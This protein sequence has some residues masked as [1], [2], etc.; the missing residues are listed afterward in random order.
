MEDSG[1]EEDQL[2]NQTTEDTSAAKRLKTSDGT[3]IPYESASTTPCGC[4]AA[5]AENSLSAMERILGYNFRNKDLLQEALTH[6]SWPYSRSYERLEF[7]GD[8]IICVTFSM[9]VYHTYPDLEPGQL[10]RIRAANISTEKLA[11]LAVRH[12]FHQYIRINAPAVEA[13]VFNVSLYVEFN[14]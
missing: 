12:G 6:S 2:A 10:S 11:R 9:F 5:V 4:D 13:K 3:H 1:S 8:A 7:V 14:F